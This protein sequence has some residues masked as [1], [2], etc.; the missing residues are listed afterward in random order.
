MSSA[1]GDDFSSSFSLWIPFIS[2]SS[3]TVVAKTSKTLLNKS[4][5]SGHPYLV[6]DLRGNTLSFSPLSMMLAVGLS[7]MTIICRTL[8]LGILM[9]VSDL[10]LFCENLYSAFILQFVGFPPRGMRLDNTLPL[11]CCS[12]F[13]SLVVDLLLFCR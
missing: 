5:E 8:G 12:C 3:L 4:E 10:L 2:F 7:Y 6:P 13:I 1:N 11:P 9:W